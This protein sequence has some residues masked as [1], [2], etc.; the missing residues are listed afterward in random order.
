MRAKLLFMCL[1]VGGLVNAAATLQADAQPAAAA[2]AEM[3]K[4]NVNVGKNYWARFSAMLLDKPIANGDYE[5]VPTGTHFK[6]DG[7]VEGLVRNVTE[8]VPNKGQYYYR[9]V[10]DNGQTRYIS[11][12]M[13]SNVA[14]DV[15][16]V[17]AAAE[18]KRRGNPR[19]GMT[20]KQVEATCWGKPDHVNRKE[21][22]RG[23]AEQY[24][25]GDGRFVY[26]HDGVVTEVQIRAAARQ[27]P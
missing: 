4:Y 11:P 17:V 19:V 9:V 25:Y 13:L 22:A 16:P 10:L 3:A 5:L 27:Q 2:E 12:G 23:I 1:A 15:D 24:V 8:Y 18:C 6:I 26:L 21:S 14:T 20:A 7:V